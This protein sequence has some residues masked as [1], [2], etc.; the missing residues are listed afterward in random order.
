MKVENILVEPLSDNPDITRVSA[1]V[2]GHDVWFEMPTEHCLGSAGDA[3]LCFAFFLAMARRGGADD[4]LLEFDSDITVSAQLLEALPSQQRVFAG[5]GAPLKPFTPVVTSEVRQAPDTRVYSSF[6][7]GVDSLY[8]AV[9][10]SDEITHLVHIHGY[11]V[12]LGHADEEAGLLRLQ[13]I[14]ERLGKPM[15]VVRTNALEV[16][17]ALKIQRLLVFGGF[18]AT[19]AHLLGGGKYYI[20]SSGP[21][22]GLEVVG[23][24]PLTDPRWSSEAVQIIYDETNDDRIEK[25]RKVD[26][27][28]CLEDV[29]VCHYNLSSNCCRCLKCI[30]TMC[31]IELQGLDSSSFREPLTPA[32]VRS[33]APLTFKVEGDEFGRYLTLAREL[34]RHDLVRAMTYAELWHR[35]KR[36]FKEV[37]Q[38]ADD[39]ILGGRIAQRRIAR[40]KRNQ[41]SKGWAHIKQ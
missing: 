35:T 21:M 20:P 40:G 10:R 28:G 26:E 22:S 37:L 6:S 12:N 15:I 32:L 2:L 34:G 13:G 5:W 24:H 14:A 25:M 9:T 19:V 1:D 27:F 18:M 29:V 36:V 33:L 31:G 8:T 41:Y 30:R 11:E 4:E 3:F 38:I 23:S 17:Q 7:G 16:Y 39:L